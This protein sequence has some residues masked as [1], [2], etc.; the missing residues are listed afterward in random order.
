MREQD[1]ENQRRPKDIPIE[2][3]VMFALDV[4]TPEEARQWMDLLG[5]HIRFFKAGLELFLAGGPGIVDTITE[6]GF[7]RQF[8]HLQSEKNYANPYPSQ[9]SRHISHII[10]F[11][12]R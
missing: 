6:R 5:G 10:R 1:N 4:E 9:R 2:E 7:T 11:H 8:Y 12:K 3:R